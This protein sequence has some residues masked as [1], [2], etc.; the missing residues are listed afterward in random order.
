MSD[1]AD[2]AA[3]RT[4]DGG[5]QRLRRHVAEMLAT[6]PGYEPSP[7]FYEPAFQFVEQMVARLPEPTRSETESLIA[8]LTLANGHRIFTDVD[9]PRSTSHDRMAI[10][11]E[12]RSRLAGHHGRHLEMGVN[13]GYPEDRVT[14]LKNH[15]GLSEFLRLDLD[16]SV[17]ADIVADCSAL[18][19]ADG[20]LDS[21]GSDSLFEHMRFPHQTIRESY[22]VL[23]PGGVMQISMP[24]YF[25]I[26]NYPGDYMRLTPQFLEET[27][28][29][30]GFERVY[31]HVYDFG[32][33][34]Y[35]LHN[36]SKQVLINDL[37]DAPTVRAAAAMHANVMTLL[38][39]ASVFDRWFHG[40]GRN[41]FIAVYCAAFKPGDVANRPEPPAGERLE[42]MLPYLVCPASGQ[43]LVR[44]GADRLASA[45][46][47]HEYSI[48][49]GI[50]V[51]LRPPRPAGGPS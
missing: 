7:D 1:H 31:C 18:P 11:A 26:H 38:L 13:F 25:T 46:G 45:D 20:S 47:A 50:P 29:E 4:D 32:G 24:F 17:P 5:W 30:A 15:F 8:R 28:R 27:C 37:Y 48:Q 10:A 23:G 19:F 44:A 36:S 3:P 42:R 16:T 22:R 14:V 49:N 35:T 43:P 51:L 34:Y 21:V 33:V 39:L 40:E 41:F 12:I 2:T 6:R 9:L